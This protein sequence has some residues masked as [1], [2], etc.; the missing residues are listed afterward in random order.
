MEIHNQDRF[1]NLLA[2]VLERDEHLIN[3]EDEFRDYAEWDSLALL[4]FM[5]M[6]EEEYSTSFKRTDLEDCITI[7]DLFKITQSSS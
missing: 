6:L 3:I 7:S 1:I 4:S 5:V 2:D